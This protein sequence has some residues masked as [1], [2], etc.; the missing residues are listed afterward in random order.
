MKYIDKNHDT[1]KSI[2][3][4]IGPVIVIIGVVFIAIGLINFF[5]SFVSFR[6]P[7]Y[8]W[9]SFVG[10]PLCA[11]GLMICRFAFMGDI[12]R[13][14]ANEIAPVAK[15]TIEYIAH[16]SKDAIQ[17]I[18]QAVGEGLNKKLSTDDTIVIRCHKCNAINSINAKFCSNCGVALQKTKICPKCGDLNDPD[19]HFCDNCGYRIG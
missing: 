14:K 10:M 13:Y 6:P 7:R 12:A 19:A 1:I 15:D 18:A 17:E 8:F 11:F 9:C 3:R 16:G 2:L 4:I 5:S